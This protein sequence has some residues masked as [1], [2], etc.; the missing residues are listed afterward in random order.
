[1]LHVLLR[2]RRQS[3]RTLALSLA[4]AP[5]IAIN[6]QT[7]AVRM[8]ATA[9]TA[10]Y[11]FHVTV[12]GHGQP[13]LLIP[14][15]MSDGSVWDGLVARYRDRYEL[16]VLTLPGFAGV[17]P[18]AADAPF[19][20]TVRDEIIHYV[21]EHRLVRPVLVGHS[22]G[23]F[24]AFSI[25]ATDP[26]AVGPIVSVDGVPFLSALTDPAATSTST[27]AMAERMQLLYKPGSVARRPS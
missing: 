5:A 11:S 1:M 18:L 25:A 22:L 23:G 4:L 9:P 13:M 2:A 16:H 24:L 26:T 19:L 10:P 12:T 14:G 3:L 17:P 21:R 7:P 20:V 8:A 15:L 6:A 27:H